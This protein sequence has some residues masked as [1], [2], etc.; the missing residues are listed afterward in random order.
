MQ[1]GGRH[2]P[3]CSALGGSPGAICL[4]E[5]PA[6]AGLRTTALLLQ[7]HHDGAFGVQVTP[8]VACGPHGGE[9]APQCRPEPWLWTRP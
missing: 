4:S 7:G 5:E 2:V 9:R 1:R 6:G 3:L 8:P